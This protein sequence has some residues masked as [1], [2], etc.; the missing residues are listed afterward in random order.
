MA[1]SS[2]HSPAHTRLQWQVTPDVFLAK[3]EA[4][5]SSLMGYW[6][7]A[8]QAISP[9]PP[10]LVTVMRV[11]QRYRRN[12]ALGL[13]SLQ[14]AGRVIAQYHTDNAVIPGASQQQRPKRW[15]RR[16]AEVVAPD[17]SWGKLK[18][19]RETVQALEQVITT[20]M[21]LAIQHDEISLLMTLLDNDL[22][23]VLETY[24]G[25]ELNAK[26]PMTL[27]MAEHQM[28]KRDTQEQKPLSPF[29]G[30]TYQW[31]RR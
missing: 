21:D 3:R 19:A 13:Q 12:V 5:R 23:V 31:A 2:P 7:Q 11:I 18:V 28:S 6:L 8:F 4:T 22:G 15:W 20:W 14:E 10:R 24:Q 16:T 30:K 9:A 17:D 1:A 26:T 27:D 29:S 25:S